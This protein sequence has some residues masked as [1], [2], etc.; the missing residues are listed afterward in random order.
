AAVADQPKVLAPVAE[1]PFL[2]RLLDML[3]RAGIRRTVLLTG[4]LGDQVERAA[5]T[6]H[7]AMELHYSRE[8]EPLGTAGALRRALPLLATPTVLLLNGDS[9]CRVNLAGFAAWHG[10]RRADLSMVLAHVADS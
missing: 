3:A 8:S 10:R 5:G 6:T 1:R 2:L 4:H 7:A 9:Y